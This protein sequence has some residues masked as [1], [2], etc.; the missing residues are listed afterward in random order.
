MLGNILFC[1]H[2]LAISL[3]TT[4]LP[5]PG[6]PSIS[7]VFGRILELS[8][9]EVPKIISSSVCVITSEK[10]VSVFSS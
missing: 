8:E 6:A 7:V 9:P 1:A 5:I 2:R 3:A 4:V 10:K